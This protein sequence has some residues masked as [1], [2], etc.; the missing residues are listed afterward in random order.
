MIYSEVAHVA[1]PLHDLNISR[2]MTSDDLQKNNILTSTN[3]SL[4]PMQSKYLAYSHI[5]LN[6]NIKMLARI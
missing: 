5:P 6:Y 1:I 2:V 4:H 3:F